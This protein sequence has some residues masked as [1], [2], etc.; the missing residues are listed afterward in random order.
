MATFKTV[1]LALALIAGATSLAIAQNGPATGGQP[2]VAGGA[3]ASNPSAGGTG[4]GM[5]PAKPAHKMTKK[6]KKSKPQ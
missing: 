6:K 2:P 4:N 1:T 5:A 3:A